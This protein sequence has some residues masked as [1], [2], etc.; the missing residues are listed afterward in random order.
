MIRSTVWPTGLQA[1]SNLSPAP[2]RSRGRTQLGCVGR[3]SEAGVAAEGVRELCAS[4]GPSERE[5]AGDEETVLF[6]GALNGTVIE[7]GTDSYRLASTRA[8]TEAP[9]KAG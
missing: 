2:V 4:S 3:R 1:P 9:A 6:S 8:R 7:T 5:H